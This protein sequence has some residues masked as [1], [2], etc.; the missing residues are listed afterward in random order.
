MRWSHRASLVL[1]ASL[2]TVAVASAAHAESLRVVAEESVFAVITHKGGFGSGLAHNHLVVARSP[3][4]ELEFDAENPLETRFS[5]AVEVDDL[6][7]DDPELQ[8]AWNARILELGILEEPMEEL[9]EKNRRKVGDAMRGKKQLDAARHP[10]LTAE[11]GGLIEAPTSHGD[12]EFPL[13]ADLQ[14]KIRGETRA[15]PA[16]VRYEWDGESLTVE[17]VATAKFSDFGIRPYSAMLGAVKNLDEFHL[18]VVFTARPT[19]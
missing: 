14:V 16:A 8:S 12:T 5:V 19:V 15:V 11:L 2:I 1:V 10:G 18:L 13:R 9:K 7:A 3:E 4:V 17:A 6:V